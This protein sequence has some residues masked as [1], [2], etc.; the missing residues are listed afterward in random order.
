MLPV[1]PNIVNI[2]LTNTFFYLRDLIIFRLEAIAKFGV[3]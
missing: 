3:V 1:L 2:V